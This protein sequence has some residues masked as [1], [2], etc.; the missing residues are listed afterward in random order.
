MDEV[1]GSCSRGQA[2]ARGQAVSRATVGRQVHRRLCWP[3]TA[4]CLGAGGACDSPFPQALLGHFGLSRAD[5]PAWNACLLFCLVNVSSSLKTCQNDVIPLIHRV[6]VFTAVYWAGH[7]ARVII[8]YR[9]SGM[10]YS[11][12]VCMYHFS[13]FFCLC[14]LCTWPVGSSSCGM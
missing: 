11:M 7:G 4:S 6:D 13:C 3:R 8:K 14:S 12:R 2:M 10:G 1:V 5:L 9:A